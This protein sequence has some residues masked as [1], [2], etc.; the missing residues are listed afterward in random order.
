M[1][2][3]RARL[4]VVGAGRWGSV[5]A[6]VLG[7]IPQCEL[8]YQVTREWRELLAKDDIDGIII[9]TPPSTHAAIGL[10]FIRK[11]VP[12]F[13]EKPLTLDMKDA[14][15]L[16]AAAKKS[17]SAVFVGHIHLFNPAYVA[18]KKLAKNTRLVLS[19]NAGPGPH[20]PDYS[21]MWD[22][23][24]HGVYLLLDVVGMMP[25]KV[26]A[27]A[28]TTLRPKT[29]LWDSAHLKLE[30][31]N[32][33]VGYILCSSLSPQKRSRLTMVGEKRT[34]VYDDILPEQ[35]VTLYENGG[36][37]NPP[38]TPAQPLTR[39]LEA[40]ITTIQKK[41]KPSAG[42]LE[43]LAVVRVLEAAERSIRA[44]GKAV[45]IKKSVRSMDAL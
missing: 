30:F 35:K 33:V 9:A 36:A 24:S 16:A 5:V 3:K 11:G 45:N 6:R 8:A 39:E 34:V 37:T 17:R 10:P 20:R 26:S 38:Y 13:I 14:R 7:T 42:I 40:F 28:S 27:L 29:K 2:A 44:G 19:E 32:G 15:A 21:A 23:G 1:S 43:G 41:S 31:K 25:K 22:Y 12:V 18:A 4:A